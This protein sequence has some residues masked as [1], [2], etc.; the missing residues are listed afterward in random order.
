MLA[1]GHHLL[2]LLGPDLE[3]A[4]QLL[5]CRWTSWLTTRSVID[6]DFKE[7]EYS[8]ILIPDFPEFTALNAYQAT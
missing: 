1:E 5:L 2:L 3:L 6:G 8:H 7:L 4:R